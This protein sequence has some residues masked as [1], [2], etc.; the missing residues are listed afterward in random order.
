MVTGE[1]LVLETG[2]VAYALP[3]GVVAGQRGSDS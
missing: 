1:A 3:S 2:Q